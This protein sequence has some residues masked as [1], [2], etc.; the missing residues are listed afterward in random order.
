MAYEMDANA[1]LV[2]AP[3]PARERA[4]EKEP[5]SS[6]IAFIL[7][8]HHAFTWDAI[9]ALPPLAAKVRVG[10]GDA[11]PETRIVESLVKRLVEDLG[12]HLLKEEKIL[13][14]YVAS[15]EEPARGE[16]C[17]GTVQNPI[18]M[19]LREHEVVAEILD[20][21]RVV[22]RRYAAPHVADTSLQELYGRLKELDADLHRHI[23]L[24]NDI[25]FPGALALEEGRPRP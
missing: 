20:E 5:L 17:F 8:T 9:A 2:G 3:A 6:L 4:W 12:P 22:T 16:S 13:F 14:P 19:M 7:E 11:H 1:G 18:R 25:L 10:H 23:R 15:L 21:L 24:E